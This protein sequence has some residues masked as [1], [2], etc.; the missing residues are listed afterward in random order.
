MSPLS[1]AI[2]GTGSVG[3]ALAQAF[4]SLGHTLTLGVRDVDALS[5]RDLADELAANVA[6][7]VEAVRGADI[8]V[9][10]VPGS[11]TVDVARSLGDLSGTLVLDATNPVGAGLLPPHQ[12]DGRS[13]AEQVADMLPGAHVVKGFNTLAAEH[14]GLG[15]LGTQPIALFLCGDDPA[16]KQTVIELAEA[17]GFE[18]VDMGGLDRARLTEPLA[19]AWITLARRQGRNVAFSLARP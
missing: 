6:P 19:L 16:A 12:P 11:V 14:M 4:G 8:V 5:A 15:R 9:L 7:P 18:P 13:L 17:L 3:S 1:I 10:A 2:I